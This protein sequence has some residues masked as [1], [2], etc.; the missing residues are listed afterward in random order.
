MDVD[1]L[2]ENKKRPVDIPKDGGPPIKRPMIHRNKTS[3]E[4]DQN[5]Q[6]SLEEKLLLSLKCLKNDHIKDLV[7]L[8]T[9]VIEKHFSEPFIQLVT[10]LSSQLKE[11]YDLSEKISGDKETFD[12]EV[13][14]ILRELCC[15]YHDVLKGDG[16][17]TAKGRLLLL[18]FL[19]S[20]V[21]TLHINPV[22]KMETEDKEMEVDDSNGLDP[23]SSSLSKIARASKI[24]LD[25]EL[26]DFFINTESQLK[27]LLSSSTSLL[28]E[29]LLQE[30][31]SSEQWQKASMINDALCKEYKMRQEVLI[32]RVDVTVQSFSWSDRTKVMADDISN[33]YDKIRKKLS[34]NSLTSI[35]DVLA[36]RKNLC[37]IE[38]TCHGDARNAT[39][40]KL[41]KH[42]MSGKLPDRGGRPSEVPP[43]PDMPS[44]QQ[45]KTD[46]G[47][48][49]GGFRGGRGGSSYGGGRGG[50][51]GGGYR[52][53]SRGGGGGDR[54][55][56]SSHGCG[57]KRW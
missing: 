17:T 38:K 14:G 15:P 45:R 9:L 4:F 23:I 51:G 29:P 39:K 13:K 57:H 2:I 21:Q 31:L 54:H 40:C 24:S 56:S 52:G 27:K 7:T 30:E 33:A 20:E 50:H 48:G 26:K 25:T 34:A 12:I 19:V 1:T 22:T 32:K 53:G 18:D 35:V 36:A 44:F 10:K 3:S 55:K 16:L 6:T 49:R 46:V 5:V 28:K 8:Q 37:V 11:T 43:P 47:G 42:L 41:N